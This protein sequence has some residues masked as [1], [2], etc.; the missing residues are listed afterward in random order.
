[1]AFNINDYEPVEI[2]LARYWEQYPDGRVDTEI[3]SHS[4]DQFIV[5]ASIY[6]NI[7]DAVPFATGYAEERVDPNPKRVN[8]ASALENCETSAIGRALANANFAPRGARPSREEMAKAGR[9]AAIAKP[10]NNPDLDNLKSALNNYSP[11]AA[12]RKQFV[13]DAIGSTELSSLNDLTTEQVT[14]V[15]TKLNEAMSA[16]FT[17]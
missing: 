12:I 5:K 13:L 2:R 15:L 6:R 4:T 11:E 14:V 7:G 1:M 10:N 9:V 3:V 17:E 16:P 8:F